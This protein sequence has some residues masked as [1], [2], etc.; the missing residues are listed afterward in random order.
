MNDPGLASEDAPIVRD[1][2]LAM[3]TLAQTVAT[4]FDFQSIA[5]HE[6]RTPFAAVLVQLEILADRVEGE[7]AEL[8]E[9]ALRST[10]RIG[11]LVGQLLAVSYLDAGQRRERVP[12]DRPR[13]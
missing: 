9:G 1:R 7:E 8:A 5:A 11:R 6:L 4:E 3:S 12:V 10:R 13:L 2:A